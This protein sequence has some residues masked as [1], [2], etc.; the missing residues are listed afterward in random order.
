MKNKKLR[1]GSHSRA[2]S[3][4]QEDF[5][6]VHDLL[7]SRLYC[8]P[9]NFTESCL[10]A[11]GLYHRWGIAPRPEDPDSIKRII[12]PSFQLVKSGTRSAGKKKR[13][14]T[15]AGAAREGAVPAWPEGVR[16]RRNAMRHKGQHVTQI[17]TDETGVH[18]AGTCNVG[19]EHERG[20]PTR[21]AR[22]LL[23][24]GLH[25]APNVFQGGDRGS[26]VLRPVDPFVRWPGRSGGRMCIEADSG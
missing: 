26:G 11:R 14:R 23:V 12:G 10:T 9:R 6:A 1:N 18:V 8:R 21:R 3:H 24:N 20:H 19:K 25:D 15:H 17:L 5:P 7:S 2:C 13:M 22:T 16:W 4:A